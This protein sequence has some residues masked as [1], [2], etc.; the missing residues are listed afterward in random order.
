MKKIFFVTPIGS[1]DSPER[2][3]SD[4][5]MQSLIQPLAKEFDYTVERS[6][7]SYRVSDKID[8]TI[9]EQI[10]DADLV[11][12][13]VTDSN[14]NVMYELG[15]RVALSKP[16]LILTQN[17][18]T[19]PFDLRSIRAME[20]E[21]IAPNIDYLVNLLR[22]NL[23]VIEDEISSATPI[24]KPELTKTSTAPLKLASIDVSSITSAN[25]AIAQTLRDRDI[26]INSQFLTAA[27]LVGSL[28]NSIDP[29]I[30]KLSENKS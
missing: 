8:T 5:V 21:I 14:P 25:S 24:K 2:K 7:T 4:F 12:A 19:L 20:Y 3:V 27:N 26:P 1:S 15:Y 29:A 22:D 11:I 18:E 28:S 16:F 30:L 13:D 23:Q 10:S 9:M 17:V 6:D